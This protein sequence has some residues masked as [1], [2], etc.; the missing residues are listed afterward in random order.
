MSVHS[1]AL[2]APY[3]SPASIGP[4]GVRSRRIAEALVKEGHEVHAIVGDDGKLG[5][6]PSGVNVL[7]AVSG[8]IVGGMGDP[9]MD[10]RRRT[11]ASLVSA[12]RR[13]LPIP[14]AHVGWAFATARDSRLATKPHGVSAIYAV[15]APFSSL[16][17]GAIL[18]RRWNVPLIGDLGDPWPLRS[19]AEARLER[20]TIRR[21]AALVVTNERTADAYRDKVSPEVKI[22]VAP[23]GADVLRRSADEVEPPLFL[24]LGTLSHLRV[25]A[26]PAFRALATL[27]REGLIRFRSHGEAWVTFS[28]ETAKH[29]LGVIPE[30]EARE[31][32]RSASALL[33]V[34]NRNAI[35]IPSKVYEIARSDLW[36]L[37]VSELER[38]PGPELLRESGHGVICSNTEPEIRAGAIE[39]LDRR[40]RGDWPKPSELHSWEEALDR[41]LGL[42]AEEVPAPVVTTTPVRAVRRGLRRARI[43]LI[44]ALM[45]DDSRSR[46]RLVQMLEGERSE[47]AA[48]PE[49]IAIRALG[50]APIWLRPGSADPDVAVGAFHGLYHLPKADLGSPKLIWDLGCN[51]GLTMR[52]MAAAFPAA[53]II[54]VDLDPENLSLA[55]RNLKP[56]ADRCEL[57]EGAIWPEPGVLT[58]GSPDGEDA[59]RVSEDGG[60]TATAI[61]LSELCERF[62]VPDYVKM[63]IEGAESDVLERETAWASDI[64]RIGVEYHAPYD[65]EECK[66]DLRELGFDQFEVHRHGLLRRGSDSVYAFRS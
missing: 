34:G 6:I 51:I 29:H 59:Y 58:Y 65:L 16:V 60:Q 8:P 61:P 1:I 40:G 42:I 41:V 30:R 48:D 39:I 53:R 26:G 62:G 3:L 24:Q 46:R 43:R 32:M 19:P 5:E 54:G 10:T 22:L 37:C 17:L 28:P 45:T 18:A 44:A 66:R 35:Q 57:L 36:A 31:L 25:D 13:V 52:Q 49:P 23:N 27:D 4:R 38:E 47:S 15:A 33:V 50:G 7:A 56:I 9:G 11:R 14:D 63:D 20:A 21:L 64:E 55:E 12:A 2:V